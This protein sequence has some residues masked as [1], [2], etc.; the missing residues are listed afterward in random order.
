MPTLSLRQKLWLPLVLAWLSLLALSVFHAWQ[1]RELQFEA[2]RAA[3]ADITDMS[4][5]LVRDLARQASEGKLTE[6]EARQQ[7]LA[8]LAAQRYG[9]DGYV[10]VVGADSVIAMHPIKPELQGRNMLAFKDAKGTPLY[11]NIA[12]AG[13]SAE[14]H[15]YV[16]YW[17]P[18][19]QS[20]AP[21]PKIAWVVRFKP[22]GWDLVAGDYVDDIE[23][24]FHRALLQSGAALLVLGLLMSALSAVLARSIERAVGGEP[25]QVARQAL[26]MAEGDLASELA[27][28]G[29]DPHSLA[30]AVNHLR[31]QMGHSLAQVREATTTIDH[32]A[33]EIA[34][35][36]LDLSQR[37]EAQASA[38]QQTAATM[39]QFSTTVQHNAD[40]AHQAKQLAQNASEVAS[41]G[42]SVVAQVVHTMKDINDS[43]R[44]IGDIIGVIDSIAFQTNILALNAAVEAARAGEQGRGFAVVASEVRQLAGRSAEAARQIKTLIH[45]SVGQVA[46]GST[47]VDQAGQTMDEV[48][49]A[50]RQVS[51]IVS[52]I[53]AASAEQSA[54]VGQIG[55]AIN[56]LDETTQQN[57]ALVEEASAATHSLAAQ[58][59]VLREQLALFRLGPVP[60]GRTLALGRV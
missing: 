53:S 19:P 56:Q 52:Q 35:G 5:S 3:L 30:H 17:W 31:L 15:G 47:L 50:I 46:Q 1:S 38:L 10:T 2:R 12:A 11:V 59:A 43:S 25:A 28:R 40:N 33:R 9:K 22:W 16:D 27:P 60:A 6:A 51:D 8:R 39:D 14:G 4:L 26:S 49:S 21:S 48:V 23:Q 32:A 34:Q 42:G 29:A 13:S 18:R 41:R 57:A 20:E 44:R 7:A 37:T 58:V 45:T 54:G 55:R 36:N 24:G